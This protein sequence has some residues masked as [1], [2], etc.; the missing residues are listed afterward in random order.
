MKN[1][2]GLK[3]KHASYSNY[4]LTKCS[5]APTQKSSQL[6]ILLKA[7]GLALKICDVNILRFNPEPATETLPTPRDVVKC[8]CPLP[9]AETLLL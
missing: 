7:Q 8:Y 2:I 3:Q 4:E 6:K 5:F 1:S 9:E